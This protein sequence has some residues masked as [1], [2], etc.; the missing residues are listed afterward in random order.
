[1]SA[2]LLATVTPV[3]DACPGD[4]GVAVSGG[5]DSMALLLLAARWAAAAG[6]RV[7][8]G[9]RRSRAP[10]GGGGRG[11]GG[12]AVLRGPRHRSRR[13]RLAGL[14]GTGEPAGCARQARRQLIGAWAREAGLGAVALGHTLDDQ[15]ETVL[16]R[17][18]RGSG[19]DGLAAM[20]PVSEAEGVLWL[21]PML[22]LRRAALRDYL[23]RARVA[24]HEDAS[25]ATRH[26]TV[27]ARARRWRRWRR[28]G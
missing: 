4:L 13:A 2:D 7:R 6:R 24:W 5:G 20:A 14:V 12:G 8:G 11:G 1:M 22:G 17:L 16:M 18:A 9:H 10:R 26:S 21:R 19:V 3:L 15:A 23:T 28:S 27:C 25:N